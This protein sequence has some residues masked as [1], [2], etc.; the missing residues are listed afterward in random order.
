VKRQRPN[1]RK[2]AEKYE[3]YERERPAEK[4]EDPLRM[5]RLYMQTVTPGEHRTKAEKLQAVIDDPGATE[6]EREAAVAAL[7]RIS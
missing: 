4:K 2:L 5:H 1:W 7:R 6:A 3:G